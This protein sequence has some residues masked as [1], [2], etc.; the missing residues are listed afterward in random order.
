MH[1]CM[2]G[3]VP[4]TMSPGEPG[5][6]PLVNVTCRPFISFSV[7]IQMF[8]F[9]HITTAKSTST[10]QRAQYS[11]D[12][13]SVYNHRL[14]RNFSCGVVIGRAAGATRIRCSSFRNS[15]RESLRLLSDVLLLHLARVV[16]VTCFFFGNFCEFRV[17]LHS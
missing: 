2:R 13:K 7:S 6:E 14:S 1:S 5:I 9:T 4:W 3:A 15:D 12:E 17:V 16:S 8:V 11:S 10:K